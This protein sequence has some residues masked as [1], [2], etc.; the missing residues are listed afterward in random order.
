MATRG[1]VYLVHARR[2]DGRWI[3]FRTCDRVEAQAL[4]DALGVP[5]VLADE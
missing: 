3:H 5:V 2:R 1:M 4:A